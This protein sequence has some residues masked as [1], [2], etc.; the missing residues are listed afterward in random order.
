MLTR[1]RPCP[2]AHL[3]T[4]TWLASATPGRPLLCREKKLMK[5]RSPI[6][7]RPWPVFPNRELRYT[8]SPNPPRR[9]QIPDPLDLFFLLMQISHKTCR[10]G[11]A[12]LAGSPPPNGRMRFHSRRIRGPRAP[13]RPSPAPRRAVNP[14]W[15]GV[16]GEPR[17]LQSLVP[18]ENDPRSCLPAAAPP[19]RPSPTLVR[20]PGPFAQRPPAR[21]PRWSRLLNPGCHANAFGGFF[22]KIGRDKENNKRPQR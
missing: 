16:R 22:L 9:P 14:Q 11:A 17:G 19:G 6:V 5:Y 7:K 21:L 13:L 3:S 1:A 10:S 4:R 18:G 8:K 2:R 12:G 20:G 15:A